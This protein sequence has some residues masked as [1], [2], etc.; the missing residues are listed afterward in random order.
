MTIK[1]KIHLIKISNAKDLVC[2]TC[3]KHMTDHCN[4]CHIVN[5]LDDELLRINDRRRI[6]GV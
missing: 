1:E 3:I 5:L 6:K 4:T 2:K